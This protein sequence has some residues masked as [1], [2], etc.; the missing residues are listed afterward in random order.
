MIIK[1]A[2]NKK[3]ANIITKE[4]IKQVKIQSDKL[5]IKGNGKTDVILHFRKEVI[6]E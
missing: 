3:L 6:K 5:C 4:F 1:E 2:N